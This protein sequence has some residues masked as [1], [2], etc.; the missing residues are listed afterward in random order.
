MSPPSPNV[1]APWK[2]LLAKRAL[3][4]ETLR[5][6]QGVEDYGRKVASGELHAQKDAAALE[7][8]AE[9]A[10]NLVVDLARELL[11]QM[12]PGEAHGIRNLTAEQLLLALRNS[13]VLTTARWEVLDDVREGRNSLQHGASFVPWRAVWRQIELVEGNIDGTIN[14][15][16]A[17]SQGWTSPS[18][19]T[20]PTFTT[21]DFT[22]RAARRHPARSAL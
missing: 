8:F 17:A 14:D 12:N 22:V 16:Q 21:A 5:Q 1:A 7:H 9:S 13:R 19:S 4:H 2:D 18:I 11:A 6:F 20:S 3:L 10:F 15:L